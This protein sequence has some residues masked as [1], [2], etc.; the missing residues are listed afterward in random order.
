MKKLLSAC[1]F[2]LA[3]QAGAQEKEI[4]PAAKGVVYGAAVATETKAISAD[5]LEQKAGAAEY[6]GLVTGTVTE[7]CQA[8]GCWFKIRKSDGT[9]LMVKNKDHGFFLPQSL[10]GKTVAVEGSAKVKEVTEAQRRHLA[11][12]AGKPKS[13][14]EKIKGTTKEVQLIASGVK[15]LD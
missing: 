7:V 11:E 4:T 5:E 12:D 8:M 13:E 1:M 10:V 3:L 9:A 14:I 2:L 15:V 6:T